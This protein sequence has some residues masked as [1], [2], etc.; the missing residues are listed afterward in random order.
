V[1]FTIRGDIFSQRMIVE[2]AV[3]V[4]LNV[5]KRKELDGEFGGKRGWAILAQADYPVWAGVRSHVAI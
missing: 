1:K 5:L 4:V 3:K 2:K